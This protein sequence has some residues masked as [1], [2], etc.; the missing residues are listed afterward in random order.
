MQNSPLP[1][2]KQA[3]DAYLKLAQIHHPD[4]EGGDPV[5]FVEVKEAWDKLIKINTEFNNQVLFSNEAHEH[6]Q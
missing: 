1:D 3:K 2:L 4:V 5:R 6:Q